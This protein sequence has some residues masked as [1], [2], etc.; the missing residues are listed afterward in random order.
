MSSAYYALV[1]SDR[2]FPHLLFYQILLYRLHLR[3]YV[4]DFVIHPQKST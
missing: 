4:K 2:P 3:K 1:P